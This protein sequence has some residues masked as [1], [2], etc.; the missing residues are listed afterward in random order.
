MR[1]F[2]SKEVPHTPKFRTVALPVAILPTPI[3][4][5]LQS[6]PSSADSGDM[7]FHF[8]SRSRMESSTTESSAAATSSA[9]HSRQRANSYKPLKGILKPSP[10]PDD[11][12]K[13]P[14]FAPRPRKLSRASPV[15]VMEDAVGTHTPRPP[16]R[17]ATPSHR[18]PP[19]MQPSGWRNPSISTEP[20]QQPSTYP[21]HHA[22]PSKPRHSSTH[23][24]HAPVYPP[25]V[26]IP[27]NLQYAYN[28][29]AVQ[30]TYA[31]PSKPHPE[32]PSTAAGTTQ[33]FAPKPAKQE[34]SRHQATRRERV[35]GRERARRRIRRKRRTRRRRRRRVNTVS[36]ASMVL[37]TMTVTGVATKNDL[38]A[39]TDGAALRLILKYSFPVRQTSSCND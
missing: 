31:F 37:E 15:E 25:G 32:R 12:V 23:A 22:F 9:H 36:I 11:P 8:H 34:R 38:G 20:S 16:S 28:V 13:I 30:P 19:S 26:P 1:W 6:Y 18:N 27:P 4:L 14:L 10:P 7:P 3:E 2:S 24:S 5:P 35:V 17:M 33:V 29:H 39:E 21:S